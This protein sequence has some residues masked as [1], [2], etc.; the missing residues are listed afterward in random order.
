MRSLN[1]GTKAIQDFRTE[2]DSRDRHRGRRPQHAA[3]PVPGRQQGGHRRGTR[4]GT[5]VSDALDQ[6]DALLKKIADYVPISTF[7]RGDNDMVITTSDGT[8]L[9]ETMPRTVSFAPSPGYT[10]GAPGNT[11]YIDNVPVSAASAATPAPA[12][13]LPA[14]CS[15]ATASPRPCRASSTKSRAA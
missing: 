9:F 3:R 4:S 2:T 14:W 8:T 12:A 13:S 5:D 6:R 1:D 10:A 7:T 11:I 15:C